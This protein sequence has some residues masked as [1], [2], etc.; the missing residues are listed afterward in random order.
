MLSKTLKC[1]LLWEYFQESQL[2]TFN[3]DYLSW[4]QIVTSAATSLFKPIE[5][6]EPLNSFHLHSSLQMCCACKICFPKQVLFW[7]SRCL[8]F[9]CHIFGYNKKKVTC[10]ILQIDTVRCNMYLNHMKDP[11]K[12]V[13]QSYFRFRSQIKELMAHTYEQTFRAWKKRQGRKWRK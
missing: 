8:L 4:K 10:H 12:P 6:A 11:V 13:M 2:S 7:K 1:E 9:S 3:T 5:Y